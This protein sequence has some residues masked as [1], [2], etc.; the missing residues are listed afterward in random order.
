MGDANTTWRH[1]PY[2]QTFWS[3][4]RI[5]IWLRATLAGWESAYITAFA[6]SS[7]VRTSQFGGS[8]QKAVSA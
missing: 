1:P 6:T 7:A 4:G 5:T 3:V 8:S 2:A